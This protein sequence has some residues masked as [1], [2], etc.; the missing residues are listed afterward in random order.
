MR[1]T[2]LIKTQMKAAPC[3][4]ELE[5]VVLGI[6]LHTL[7][8]VSV[9]LRFL[10]EDSF[11]DPIH[12]TIFKAMCDLHSKSLPTDTTSV[13]YHLKKQKKDQEVGGFVFISNL[14]NDNTTNANFEY[15]CHLVEQSAILRRLIMICDKTLYE[16]FNQEKDVFD[17]VEEHQRALSTTGIVIKGSRIDSEDRAND[18]SENIRRI[19]N[20]HGLTGITTGLPNVDE[21]TAGYQP[22]ELVI[23]AARPGMGKSSFAIHQA[24]AAQKS[25]NTCVLFSL[26]MTKTQIGYREAAMFSGV[27]IEKIK[28][29]KLDSL[30]YERT[31]IATGAIKDHGLLVDTDSYLDM[32]T[33][34][35]KLYSYIQE[36]DVKI[37]II[38]YL[39]LMKLHGDKGDTQALKV[40][41]ITRDIKLMAKDF[42]IPLLLLCQLS[43]SVETRGGNKKP[44]LS[45]LRD[46]GGIEENAD[47]VMFLHRPEYYDENATDENGES[48]KN[49]TCIYLAKNRQGRTG[50]IWVNSNLAINQ[51]W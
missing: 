31:I 26:E 4:P 50:D 30:D 19:L 3:V 36:H 39:G 17:I 10:K 38:D 35:A 42:N 28:S 1:K 6:M 12:A 7:D 47:Q 27:W 14:R 51:Y 43:R 41:N 33:L 40:S 16:S 15:N 34:R 37:A 45:D 2:D 5:K 29:G 23:I 22:G 20:G 25:K 9:G 24:Y 49:K 21:V 11:Y 13:Y 46:S 32:T 8:G 44:Q 18:V 48:L